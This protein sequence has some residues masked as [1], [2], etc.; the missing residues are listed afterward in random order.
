MSITSQPIAQASSANHA[1]SS[2]G[3]RVD[4]QASTLACVLAVQ[5]CHYHEPLLVIPGTSGQRYDMIFA[6]DLYA[7][8]I[9]APM[10]R[11][12]NTAPMPPNSP[13]RRLLQHILQTQL[14]KGNNDDPLQSPVSSA[15]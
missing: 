10:D 14:Q 8:V 6:A 9:N 13:Q 2:L 15:F 12:I 11:H 4:L 7:I 3:S 1:L 5:S